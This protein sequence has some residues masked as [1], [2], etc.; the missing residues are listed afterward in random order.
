ML[1]KEEIIM[2]CQNCG[3]HEAEYHYK[4]NVN[5][6]VTE[7]HLCSE[8]AKKLGYS[9]PIFGGTDSFLG[10]F[11]SDF[12]G[13]STGLKTMAPGITC[14][15]CGSSA[16]DISRSGK[17]GCAQCYDTFSDML[18]PYIKRIHGSTEHTGKIPSDA[19]AEIKSKRQLVQLREELKKAIEN[20]EFEK[21]A[22]LRDKIKELE[23]GAGK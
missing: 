6:T 8:C 1:Y 10:S 11:L 18:T 17:V 19:G 21:A 14:P 15:L 5:G 2:L 13:G 23:G 22:E 3:K 7:Q 9:V 20:Q 12:F 16:S 4:S